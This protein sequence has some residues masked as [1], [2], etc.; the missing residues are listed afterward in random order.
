MRRLLFFT[1]VGLLLLIPTA[2]T[3]AQ[4]DDDYT[5]FY[6]CN[7]YTT[8]DNLLVTLTF[9]SDL[10]SLEAALI[11]A[12]EYL[13]NCGEI[14][15]EMLLN[16]TFFIE[17]EEVIPPSGEYDMEGFEGDYG[18]DNAFMNA[19]T[20]E[21][22]LRL[23]LEEQDFE[24]ANLYLCEDDQLS[25]DEMSDLELLEIDT[26]DCMDNTD[27]TIVCELELELKLAGEE[28]QTLAETTTFIVEDGLFC[29]QD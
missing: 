11:Y 26:L 9:V 19:E 22:V 7:P 2:S 18:G 29:S 14:W 27:G 17:T 5:T 10:E 8:V 23:V 20:L 3:F 16:G 28:A 13:I 1:L 6:D 21:Y 4:L 24:T 25:A 12:G 15:L